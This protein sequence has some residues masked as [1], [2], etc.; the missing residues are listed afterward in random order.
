MMAKPSG[1]QRGH[2]QRV[3]GHLLVGGDDAVHVGRERVA[4]LPERLE[5]Q[6]E[7]GGGLGPL[8]LEVLGRGDHDDSRA[9]GCSASQ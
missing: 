5:L 1:R 8:P 2:G 4:G 9:S 6:V 3:R 7:G